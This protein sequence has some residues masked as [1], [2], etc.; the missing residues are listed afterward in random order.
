M[1]IS[2]ILQLLILRCKMRKRSQKFSHV[3]SVM[4]RELNW[5]LWL[6]V[7]FPQTVPAACSEHPFDDVPFLSVATNS[8]IWKPHQRLTLLCPEL[9]WKPQLTASARLPLDS[10]PFSLEI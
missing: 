9:Y 2:N 6:T 7:Q 5:K 3:R 4:E 10:S 8:F 1:T